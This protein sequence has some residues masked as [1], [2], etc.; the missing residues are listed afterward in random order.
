[1]GQWGWLFPVMLPKLAVSS[2]LLSSWWL[3]HVWWLSTAALYPLLHT[4]PREHI[5][6]WQGGFLVLFALY[7]WGLRQSQH[8]TP[9]AWL[10][11][12]AVFRLGLLVAFPVLSDD[13]YRFLWDGWVAKQGISPYSHTPEALAGW[14]PLPDYARTCFTHMNSPNY[15]SPYPVVLQA[16]F[17]ACSWEKI[18]ITGSVWLMRLVQLVC[19]LLLGYYLLRLLRAQRRMVWGVAALL[20]NPLVVMEGV[21]SLHAEMLMV[22]PWLAAV[23]AVGNRRPTTAA[24]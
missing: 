2:P 22:W 16:L 23:V 5:W 10:A 19:E 11:I 4:Q 6:W 20:W 21:G 24:V 1:M 8:Y 12:A 18:G 14:L 15:H 9:M 17:F 3:R 13:V 7:V